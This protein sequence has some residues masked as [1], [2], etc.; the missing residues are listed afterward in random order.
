MG[1]EWRCFA[2]G[3]PEPELLAATSEEREDV[4]LLAER[5][6]PER[7]LKLRE[8]ERVELKLREDRHESGDE[9]WAKVFAHDLPVPPWEARE[10][11]RA[12]LP[13]G[14][15][16]VR[17]IRSASELVQFVH[18]VGLG[19][20]RLIPVRKRLERSFQE[21]VQR[22]RGALVCAGVSYCTWALEGDE[23][24]DLVQARTRLAAPPHPPMGYAAFLAGLGV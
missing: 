12:L 4:Y 7:N 9:L 11:A 15:V 6:G 20:G 24:D 21:G 19:A 17:P 18:D 3:E 14:R 5:L 1:W 16:P 2:P 22:E 23:R 13:G 10:L 8:G